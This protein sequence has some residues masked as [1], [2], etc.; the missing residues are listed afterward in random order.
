MLQDCGS[1]ENTKKFA[2]LTGKG[3]SS[4]EAD[5]R[6]V[7]DL[8]GDGFIGTESFAAVIKR[9]SVKTAVPCTH[10]CQNCRTVYS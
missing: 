3:V 6:E 10:E 2:P 9:M 1:S 4:I 7:S 8:S 5:K